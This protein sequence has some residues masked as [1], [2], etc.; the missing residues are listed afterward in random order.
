MAPQPAGRI[1][2]YELEEYLGGGMADVW[3]ARDTLIGR[4]VAVKILKGAYASDEQSRLRFLREAQV[5]GSL[6]HD[7]VIRI[8]DFGQDEANRPFM[9]MEF[10]KGEDLSQTI[11]AGR[12]GNLANKLR[13]CV[14]LASALGYIH[15]HRSVHR[16]IKPANIFVTETGSVKLMDFGIARPENMNLTEAGVAIGTPSYMAPEQIRAEKVTEQT[17]IFSFGVLAYELFTGAKAFPADSYE[18]VFYA[19]L[20]EPL[21]AE[22]LQNAGAPPD[23]IDLILRCTAKSSTLRPASFAAILTELAQIRERFLP[24]PA[25]SSAVPAAGAAAA[26]ATTTSE[27]AKPRPSQSN[28]RWV[29]AVIA[30]GA[31]VVATVIA[32]MTLRRDTGPGGRGAGALAKSI[33]TS[34]GEMLL[35]PA[36]EFQFGQQ[37][38][39]LSLDAYYIDRT[40]V[41]NRAYAEFAKATGHRLPAGFPANSPTLPVVNVSFEDATAF[42]KWAGA[43]LPSM[44]QWEKAA[45]GI[46]GRTY[47]WGAE[48]RAGVAAVKGSP[49]APVD[50]NAAGASPF[51]VLNTVGNVWEWVAEDATPSATALEQFRNL[52]E[53][54]LTNQDRWAH[55]RG[56][57]Y[58]EPLTNEVMW[59]SVIVPARFRNEL[60]GF[61]CVRPAR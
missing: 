28:A 43:G 14:E 29:I 2:K 40:E 1:G 9:V 24:P 5:A 18:R 30:C 61:R 49:L 44:A 13:I 51:G 11:A 53:P 50:S 37:K 20:N 35:V 33:P 55:I 59:N 10:L 4:T 47:P 21:S 6:V 25:T 12:A 15:Q 19:I 3:R 17:D 31:I 52:L 56:G 36:G 42:A 45:R 27:T 16:D 23:L 41:S 58:K 60:I 57:S 22:Q 54:P 38:R 8:Y 34:R 48:E 32:L 46:D 26:A 7:N 39:P